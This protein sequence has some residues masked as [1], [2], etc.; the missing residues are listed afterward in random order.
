MPF[1]EEGVQS[2][3]SQ[4]YSN[5]EF[6][7]VNDGSTD[8][9]STYLNSINDPRVKVF[10]Q[11]NQG[12]GTTLNRLFQMA[13]TDWI[14]RMDADDVAMPQRLARQVQHITHAPENLVMV[15]TGFHIIAGDK[16]MPSSTVEVTNEKIVDLF[17][18]GYAGICHPTLAFRRSSY[19]TLGPM[20]IAGAGEDIDF[21]LRMSEQGLCSNV[22]DDLLGYRMTR[23]SLSYSK[24]KELA[25][26]Y[27]Y[28][29]DAYRRRTQG[30]SEIGI[31]AFSQHW[32]K[33]PTSLL[34]L[35]KR[36]GNMLYRESLISKGEDRRLR[37][38]AF[39]AAA[40][41]CDPS[42]GLRKFMRL[43]R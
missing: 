36:R 33:S 41:L 24:L 22:P 21:C 42:A 26:G 25:V 9:T 29:I 19:L 16:A 13:T 8:E 1:L 14:F 34:S 40:G 17:A 3:L 11:N 43:V 39:L 27:D 2:I 5:F 38:W 35:V 4:S 6:L 37:S 10:H 15:G 20:R 30:K 7:I 23:S 12:L 31:E 18:N 32:S 28:A